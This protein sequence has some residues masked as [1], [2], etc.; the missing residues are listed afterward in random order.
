MDFFF[1][2]Q[3]CT[4]TEKRK[5]VPIFK[6]NT[7]DS[8]Y[9]DLAYHEVKILSLT[10]HE[11]LTTGKNDIVEKRRNCSS[12]AISPLFHNIFDISLNPRVQLHIN[13]LSG[14]SNYIFPHFCKSDMLRYGYLEVFQ[15][16][17]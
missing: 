6:V 1:K 16:V 3:Y 12:G 8:R 15:R 11:I 2:I 13:L 9:L 7:A 17:P 4:G 10:K 14:C 5:D